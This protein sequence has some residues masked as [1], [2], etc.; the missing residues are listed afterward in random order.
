MTRFHEIEEV[1]HSPWATTRVVD[2]TGETTDRVFRSTRLE[3]TIYNEMRSADSDLTAIEKSAMQSLHSFPA[4]A[5]DIFQSFYSLALRWNDE[6]SL[7]PAAKKFHTKI[8]THV[9]E[10]DDY[11]ALKNICEGRELPAYEAA[12]E[13]IARTAGELEDL[14]A[15]IGGERGAL[16]TLEK[17]IAGRD[18]AVSNLAGILDQYNRTSE[19]SPLLDRALLS[20]ANAAESKQR[21]VEAVSKMIDTSLIRRGDCVDALMSTAVHAAKDKAEETQAIIRAWSDEPGEMS[22]NS[23]NLALLSRVRQSAKLRDVSKYLGRFREILAQGRKNGYAY[24]RGETYALELGNDLSRTITSEL[25]MLAAPE[26]TPLFVRKYQDKHLKQYRRRE[27]IHKGMGDIICCLDESDSTCGDAE[28]WG[29]A[30]A[31]TL[32]EIAASQGRKFA[33]IHF[34][35]AGSFQTDLFLPGHYTAEDKMRAAETFLGGGTNFETPLSEAIRLMEQ[36]EFENA[37]IVFITDGNCVLS[38]SFCEHLAP[39]QTDRRFTITAILLD[40]GGSV[41]D[42]SLKTFCQK[43]YRTSELTGDEIVQA[44][45]CDRVPA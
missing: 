21:Q 1:L 3:D 23:V 19:A 20:A 41:S 13:F 7:T 28:A 18:K 5:R 38:E 8:L 37:D 35:G 10:Q 42:V 9:T 30:V 31:M 17:L 32:Q 44:L 25:A 45:I 22:R 24:G 12:S 26:T 14:L 6:N 34:S 33:L 27:P 36:N 39:I 4:L 29:K 15:E 11:P 2:N 40:A 43:I 16:N